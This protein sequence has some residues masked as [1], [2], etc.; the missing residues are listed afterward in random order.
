M[1]QIETSKKTYETESISMRETKTSKGLYFINDA[2]GKG[3]YANEDPEVVKQ[4]YEFALEKAKN[5]GV[6]NTRELKQY[7]REI[8]KEKEAEN[9]EKE[10]EGENE[11]DAE[12]K[13]LENE[14]QQHIITTEEV[15]KERE[16]LVNNIKQ[17]Q[18]NEAP[19]KLQQ[20]A[21]RVMELAD[22]GLTSSKEAV[23]SEEIPFIKNLSQDE[24]TSFVT[25][26][27]ENKLLTRANAAFKAGIMNA[28]EKILTPFRAL[29]KTILNKELIS[30]KRNLIN[31]Q[32]ALDKYTNSIGG[33]LERRLEKANAKRQKLGF[34]PYPPDTMLCY[35][36]EQERI[37]RYINLISEASRDIENVQHE[38]DFNSEKHSEKLHYISELK[39]ISKNEKISPDNKKILYRMENV[40]KDENTENEHERAEA[41][42]SH[43]IEH[44]NTEQNTE[45]KDEDNAIVLPIYG[46]DGKQIGEQKISQEE[47]DQMEYQDNLYQSEMD[48]FQENSEISEME[49]EPLSEDSAESNLEESSLFSPVNERFSSAKEEAA[50][51]K[52]YANASRLYFV[53]ESKLPLNALIEFEANGDA[54]IAQRSEY[55]ELTMQKYNYENSNYEEISKDDTIN[56]FQKN[57]AS[58]ENAIKTQL[59][60]V[61][62]GKARE[63]EADV[64]EK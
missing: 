60:E 15:L 1:I 13:K 57:P 9:S 33:K 59:G 46:P 47:I 6:V 39:A 45:E 44:E 10:P 21:N 18:E 49:P 61:L 56:I 62:I 31:K 53:I 35:P 7:E 64:Q 41:S 38:I 34:E 8:L 28:Y 40:S 55:G 23:P 29:H 22:K 12:W 48:E 25:Y 20:L 42:E 30:A 36:K 52:N 17:M 24:K 43:N 58:F 26:K 51:N 37:S 3:I 19:E 16:K 4:V 54:F 14:L 63:K 32:K 50:N 27:L 11:I 2:N 5:E